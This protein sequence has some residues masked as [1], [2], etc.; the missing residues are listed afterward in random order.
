M[1]NVLNVTAKKRFTFPT[2]QELIDAVVNSIDIVY[3]SDEDKQLFKSV[4]DVSNWSD[5][6]VYY[7]SDLF[8]LAMSTVGE[9]SDSLSIYVKGSTGGYFPILVQYK[10]E[11]HPTVVISPDKIIN[12]KSFKVLKTNYKMLIVG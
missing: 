12:G 11:E 10:D 2:K 6:K 9:Y 3:Q 7:E 4:I 1:S 8:D 5:D